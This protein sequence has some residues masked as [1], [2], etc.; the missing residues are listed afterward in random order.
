[1]GGEA[2]RTA[3]GPEDWRSPLQTILKTQ[4]LRYWI[5]A[6]WALGV[7]ATAGLVTGAIWFG[8]TATVGYLRGLVEKRL[9]V[10][11]GAVRGL[12]FVAAATL[13]TIVWATAPI[14]VWHSQAAFAQGVAVALLGSGYLLVFTQL[15][16]T[17]RQALVISSPYS[18]AAIL[19]GLDVWGTPGFWQYLAI[20][21]FW[22]SG[23]FVHVVLT[24]IQDGKILAFQKDQAR[25]IREL[26]QARDKADA[27][28]RAKSA[29]LGVISHEL[30]TP[31]NGVLGAAQLLDYT[32]LEPSQREY[33]GIIRNSGDS[34][35]TLLNDILD[36]TK[37]E[38]DRMELETIPV[39]LPGLIEKV[40]GV[41][42][43]RAEEKG[44]AYSFACSPGA[45]QVI[46]GDPTRLAQILHNL[47][48]NAIKFTEKG[49]VGLEVGFMPVG[50][51]RARLRFSVTDTGCG[52][53]EP[54]QERLFEPFEQLDASS[55]RRF[56][57][58]GLG[59]AISRRLAEMMGGSLTVSSRIGRGS[60]FTLTFETD[61]LAWA[62]VDEPE[63]SESTKT[64]APQR[65]LRVLVVEDHPVNRM[66]L[67]S[68][69][70]SSGHAVAS[71]E[72]GAVGLELAA[73][74]PFDVIL[75]DVNMPVMDG[76]AATAALRERPGPNQDAPVAIL[77]ASARAEDHAAGYAAG[78]DAYLTKPLDFSAVTALLNRVGG[79][80]QGLREAA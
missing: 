50:E 73:F 9:A 13:S 69:L 1:M 35:L 25:L 2:D 24:A 23:I 40:G 42:K 17:P 48:S 29:F 47:L 6:A 36:L 11:K 28:S 65:L 21:P 49:R 67:E 62:A 18:I 26:E 15:R 22:W 34:L 19:L 72:N 63:E 60:A 27:A 33:V 68:W 54:D 71:A 14:L 31:L 51:N 55:T 70:A 3:G 58:T 7:T 77:S 75:M 41:W 30:R 43:A 39:E 12:P 56:G 44:V 57:G 38:A 64:D 20:G 4:Y 10:R 5:I 79:G 80:R 45:P 52:I 74:Q 78:A 53:S 66:L 37:I 16:S 32:K 76:L 59:L 46:S 61:V 8:A